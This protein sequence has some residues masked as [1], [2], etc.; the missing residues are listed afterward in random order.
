MGAECEILVGN[1]LRAGPQIQG[2][3][4]AVDLRNGL[5]DQ[6]ALPRL[7]P[8][9]PTDDISD[10][11]PGRGRR[12]DQ[13]HV[14]NGARPRV[15]TAGHKFNW[16]AMAEVSAG[17]VSWALTDLPKSTAAPRPKA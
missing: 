12:A 16:V 14:Q 17:T 4:S 9:G 3:A 2:N 5:R 10:C 13:V 6:T 11:V 7:A 15:D 1:R 8:R